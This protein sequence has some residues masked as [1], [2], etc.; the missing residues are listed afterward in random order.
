M[1]EHAGKENYPAVGEVT[2]SK[3][4]V[5]VLTEVKANVHRNTD[6]ILE[7]EVAK[8]K[9]VDD[10]GTREQLSRKFQQKEEAKP[11][12]EETY[13]A[14]IHAHTTARKRREKVK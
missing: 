8:S 4:E 12:G 7:S 3:M 1:S 2:V 14:A 5:E 13:L 10:D 9:A 6:P 11:E